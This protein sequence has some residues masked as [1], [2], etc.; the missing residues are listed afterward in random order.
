MN[1]ITQRLEE[2]DEERYER[3]EACQHDPKPSERHEHIWECSKC[4][5]IF[6]RHEAEFILGTKMKA[7]K[8]AE[9]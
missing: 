7:D 4:H 8:P 2:D 6:A 1:P 5:R 9:L 3:F